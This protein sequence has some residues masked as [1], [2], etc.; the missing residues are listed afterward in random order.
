[1]TFLQQVI[2]ADIVGKLK[3]VFLAEMHAH[4]EKI[5]ETKDANAIAIA[6]SEVEGLS[7]LFAS[8]EDAQK[9]Y[10]DD[11]N[12]AECESLQIDMTGLVVSSKFKLPPELAE[13]ED[14]FY[15]ALMLATSE[16]AGIEVMDWVELHA[17]AGKMWMDM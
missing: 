7:V 17:R 12:K 16:V 6:C 2:K 5:Q 11:R 3:D 15:R 1:M 4:P 8:K 10:N 14:E 9:S 13:C